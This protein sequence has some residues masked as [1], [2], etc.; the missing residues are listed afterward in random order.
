[1]ASSASVHASSL[2]ITLC[3]ASSV[4]MH[5]GVVIRWETEGIALAVRAFL[6]KIADKLT[7]G[8]DAP[9][10]QVAVICFDFFTHSRCCVKFVTNFVFAVSYSWS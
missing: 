9:I 7:K 6:C 2:W 8:K 5:L 4:V 3:A 10:Y 1:M